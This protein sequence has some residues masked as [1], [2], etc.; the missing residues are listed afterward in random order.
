MNITT[1]LN[2]MIPSSEPLNYSMVLGTP[3]TGCKIT[4]TLKVGQDFLAVQIGAK[5]NLG[6]LK[7]ALQ[8]ETT[9]ISMSTQSQDWKLFVNIETYRATN[10]II[11]IIDLINKSNF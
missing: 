10:T 6:N 3:D 1:F 4:K 2:S 7:I 8:R 9:I 5:V 11:T